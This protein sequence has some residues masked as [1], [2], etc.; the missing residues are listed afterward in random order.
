MKICIITGPSVI[1][2]GD[3]NLVHEVVRELIARGFTIYVCDADGVDFAAAHQ[4]QLS[5]AWLFNPNVLRIF[6]PRHDLGRMPAGLA[7]RSTRMV[8][9][10]LHECRLHN[11]DVEGEEYPG[12]DDPAEII[13]VGFPNKPCPAGIVPAKFWKSGDSGTWST[14]ALAI[15]HGIETWIAPLTV[16]GAPADR[17]RLHLSHICNHVAWHFTP[18][19]TLFSNLLPSTAHDALCAGY[20]ELARA[21]S[22][23]GN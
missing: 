12:Y 20:T 14:L 23:D 9:E 4:V 13:C 1:S 22:A 11:Q 15:G 3:E 8:K 17:F 10:A 16:F 18:A 6:E 19:P 5:E 7:E 2:A 21:N